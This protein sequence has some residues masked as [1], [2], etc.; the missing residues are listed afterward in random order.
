MKI[1]SVRQQNNSFRGF[2]ATKL[3]TAIAEHPG[4]VAGLATASVIS[5]KLVLSAFEALY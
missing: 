1:E 2:D 3:V 4:L 5:Q